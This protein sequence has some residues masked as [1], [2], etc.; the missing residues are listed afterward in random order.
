MT[1]IVAGV[2]SEA[3]GWLGLRDARSLKAGHGPNCGRG[4]LWG[5]VW[6]GLWAASGLKAGH[7]PNPSAGPLMVTVHPASSAP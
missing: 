6:P 1:L 3:S 7:A 4:P 2:P 5:A